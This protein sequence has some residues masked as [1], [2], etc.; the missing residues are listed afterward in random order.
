MYKS[1]W[2]CQEQLHQHIHTIMQ[3][4]RYLTKSLLCCSLIISCF[5]FSAPAQIKCTIK[6]KVVGRPSQKILLM[7]ATAD[8]RSGENFIPIVDNAFETSFAA[9]NE[10]YCLIFDDEV[11]IGGIQPVVFFPI[12]GE[13][14][15][16]LHSSED[17]MK[18]KIEGGS[19]NKAHQEFISKAIGTFGA[20]RAALQQQTRELRNKDE[21]ES[22]EMKVLS[23]QFKNTSDS[24]IKSEL[25]KQMNALR[26]AGADLSTKGISLNQKTEDLHKRM[27]EWGYKYIKANPSIMSYYLMWHDLMYKKENAQL[28]KLASEAYPLFAKKFPNHTYTT[29]VGN[30]LNGSLKIKPG[31]KF[32]DFTAQDL[33]GSDFKLSNLIKNKVVLIDLWG[34]WCGPCISKTRTMI[35]VYEQYKNKGFDI[36]GVAREFKN[37]DALKNRLSKEKFTWTNLIELNDKNG[38]WNKYAISNGAGRM[39]LV[40][41][42]GVILATDPSAEEVKKILSDIL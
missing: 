30:E 37:A 34:S 3:K 41:K 23:Q 8:F 10:A 32:I 11:Q 16:T 38:I 9:E 39:L 18:N 13:I 6:G 36:I 24:Q 7:K 22:S 14:K 33:E 21:Y 40:D 17:F 29:R 35:P 2:K 4:L 19:L 1:S 20:E 25:I 5:S 12:N 27:V 31:E 26:K 28:V 15:F 42:N